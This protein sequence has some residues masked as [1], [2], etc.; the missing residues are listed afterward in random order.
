MN[1]LDELT[2]EVE[3]IAKRAGYN[4]EE[5]KVLIWVGK[6]ALSRGGQIDESEL[7]RHLLRLGE[8]VVS[9]GGYTDE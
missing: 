1:V 2:K 7:K 8:S 3:R 9:R 5:T 4:R 6:K